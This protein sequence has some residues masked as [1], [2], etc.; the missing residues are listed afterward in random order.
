MRK[1]QAFSQRGTFY[2]ITC[3]NSSKMLTSKETK[4]GW[5]NITD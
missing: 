4:K 5:G 2:K 1:H 3:L